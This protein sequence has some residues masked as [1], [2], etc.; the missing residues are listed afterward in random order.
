M[1]VYREIISRSDKDLNC[2]KQLLVSY[3]NNTLIYGATYN[4]LINQSVFLTKSIEK[5]IKKLGEL[6]C[7]LYGLKVK[8]SQIQKT[9]SQYFGIKLSLNYFDTIG[10]SDD[11]QIKIKSIKSKNNDS[12]GTSIN[13]LLL[14]ATCFS[15]S[16]D[17]SYTILRYNL[18]DTAFQDELAQYRIELKLVNDIVT[19]EIYL[20]NRK[21]KVIIKNNENLIRDNEVLRLYCTMLYRV[22]C[23]DILQMFCR[24]KKIINQIFSYVQN[25]SSIPDIP[26]CELNSILRNI[27]YNKHT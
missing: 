21:P 1:N 4:L 25:I 26:M 11:Y 16:S 5:F 27:V 6:I 24:E 23:Y 13:L 19:K 18:C 2:F 12:T 22:K 8:N 20:A 3:Q 15:I 10:E 7:K 17:N 9:L 14:L